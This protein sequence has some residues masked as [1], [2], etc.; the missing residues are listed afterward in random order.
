[1]TIGVEARRY[2]HEWNAELHAGP[3]ALLLERVR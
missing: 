2:H 3:L 1:M